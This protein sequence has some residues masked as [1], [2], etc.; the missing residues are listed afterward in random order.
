MNVRSL[1]FV[2]VTACAVDVEIPQTLPVEVASPPM[3]LSAPFDIYATDRVRLQ[4]AGANPGD[5]VW[6]LASTNGF[7]GSCPGVLGGQCLDIANPVA[8]GSAIANAAGEAR[9]LTP[10]IPMALIDSLLWFEVAVVAG[11]NSYTSPDILRQVYD[12]ACPQ[13]VSDFWAETEAI[14][15]C[16]VASDCGQVLTGTSC[17]CTRSWV[18]RTGADTTDFYDLLAD[19]G[20]CGVGLI[21]TCDCPAAIGFDCINNTC[22][23]NYL[24]P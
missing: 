24:S 16:A 19:A 15:S 18:A 23:W 14:R 7:G 3:T 9:L 6:F 4:A 21:S 20:S 1:L 22:T 8:L 5:R 11:A 17:G 13:I 2:A 12:P 10:R